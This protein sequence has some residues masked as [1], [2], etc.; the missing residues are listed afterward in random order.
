MMRKLSH[1]II[2][3]NDSWDIIAHILAVDNVYSEFWMPPMG[4]K[5]LRYIYIHIGCLLKGNTL[6][7]EMPMHIINSGGC[8]R[9][10]GRN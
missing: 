3:Q 4:S 7:T 8:S 6:S 10:L 2:D 9:E 5:M 1:V